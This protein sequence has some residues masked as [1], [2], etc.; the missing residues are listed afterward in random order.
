MV[1]KLD[2]DS[3]TLL[4][5][6]AP[7]GAPDSCQPGAKNHFG[8]LVEY[9]AKDPGAIRIVRDYVDVDAAVDRLKD[10]T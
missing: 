5:I 9:I 8:E 10:L 3:C 7:P 1:R 4:V 6:N 2:A